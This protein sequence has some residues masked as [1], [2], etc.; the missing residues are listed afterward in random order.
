MNECFLNIDSNSDFSI[1]NLPY[2]VFSH[3]SSKKKIGVA[4]GEWVLDL[5]ELENQKILQSN[6]F[7]FETLNHFIKSGSAN[8]H[9]I[10]LEIKKILSVGSILET[11][12]QL[13]D[14]VLIPQS[15]CIMHLPV[16]IPNYTDFYS[17]R[18]HA[19][20]VGM[21]FRDPANALLPNWLHVPVGYHGR[22]SS[23]VISGTNIKRPCG[24][25][26][27]DEA[28]LPSFG[29]SKLLDFELEMGCILGKENE[30]GS[31][32]PIEK[33]HEYIFGMVLV[34][35]WSARD[36]QKWEYVP[37]GPFLAK[38][39][40]TSISPW[41]VPLEALI[42]FRVS[43]PIQDPNP[44]PYLK[45]NDPWAFDINLSAS[46]MTSGQNEC[47][48]ISHTNYKYMYWDICQQ[49]THHAS[50]GCNLQIGDLLASG[51]IS[52]EAP[53]SYGSLLELTWKGTKPLSLPNGELRKF[54]QDGDSLKISGFCKNDSFKIGFGEV[55]GQILPAE[56]N[57]N[58]LI[59]N[60]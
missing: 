6:F 32:I 21:M 34:N 1:N 5:S 57:K 35:D 60:S 45:Q 37:L 55:V 28:K 47:F 25:T 19:T 16:S 40:A 36:I 59:E 38:N 3:K 42:P 30:L 23:V 58:Y 10:R 41:I 4:I 33:A 7:Q 52:G 24:Q 18:E 29:P 20:N 15:K 48:D 11:N 50:N 17:S 9:N 2:G 31:P 39:F 44:L 27:S 26:K 54:L 46:I 13:R 49:I 43:G 51:T 56:I 8:W 14:S 22:A 53:D 12:P